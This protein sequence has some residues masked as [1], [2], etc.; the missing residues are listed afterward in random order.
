[1]DNHITHYRSTV[2]LREGWQED[3]EANAFELCS[4]ILSKIDFINSVEASD[5]I[6][7]SSIEINFDIA[8]KIREIPNEVSSDESLDYNFWVDVAQGKYN[9]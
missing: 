1:M 7:I 5:I 4:G 2:Q 8:V 9:T 6:E 3:R